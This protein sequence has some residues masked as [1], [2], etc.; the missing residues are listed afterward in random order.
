M[1]VAVRPWLDRALPA[2]CGG[3]LVP[4]QTQVTRVA[5]LAGRRPFREADLADEFGP[6]PVHP[7]PGQCAPAE[8]RLRLFQCGEGRVQA[9][10]LGLVE[11]GADLAGVG[12]LAR[13]VVIADEQGAEAGPAALR[14]GEATD[15]ELLTVLCLELQPVPAAAGGV[16]GG[17]PLRDQPFPAAALS[18]LP[19]SLRGGR[20]AAV[21]GG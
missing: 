8:R 21:R 1:R 13:F 3:I 10:Q 17:G 9:R 16:A 6:H 5:E 11:A 7:G 12:E 19:V 15:H 14:I 2:D 18:L 4:V 20:A